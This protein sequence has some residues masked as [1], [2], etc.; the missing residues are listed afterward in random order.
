MCETIVSMDYSALLFTIFN[1][2]LSVSVCVIK[3]RKLTCRA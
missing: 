3:A 2:F 1:S